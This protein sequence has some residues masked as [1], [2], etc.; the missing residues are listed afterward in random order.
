MFLASMSLAEQ[1]VFF[2]WLA[3]TQ[4]L[5]RVFIITSARSR[6]LSESWPRPEVGVCIQE[7]VVSLIITWTWFTPGQVRSSA[8]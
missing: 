2:R 1:N 3:G 8:L 7:A 5:V 6:R 4:W